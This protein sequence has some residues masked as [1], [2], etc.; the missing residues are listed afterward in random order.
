MPLFYDNFDN[1][2][3]QLDQTTFIGGWVVSD[4]TVDLIGA[5]DFYDALPGNGRYLDLDG[6]SNQA[7]TLSRSLA[8]VGGKTYTASF[9]LAGNPGAAETNVV[10]VGFGTVSTSFSLS[11]A[12]VP[13]VYAV[14][15]TPAT[16]G[17]YVL[18]FHNQGGD[19]YGALLD[20]VSV[21]KADSFSGDG[22][23]FTEF[24]SSLDYG[25][26]VT[27]QPD[28]KILLAGDSFYTSNS[29]A[30]VRYNAN[31]MLDN[32]FSFDGRAGTV[33]SGDVYDVRSVLDEV[34]SV[35][36]QADGNILLAGM[37]SLGGN[38]ALVRYR[39]NGELDSSF[40]GDGMLTTSFADGGSRVR[41]VTVQDDGK[42]LATGGYNGDFAL[43]RYLA[44]GSLDPDFSGTLASADFGAGDTGYSIAVQADGKI[45]VAG[46]TS[47]ADGSVQ[48]FALAR[49]N[50]NGGLDTTFSG[51]GTVTTDIGGGADYA[52]AVATQADG[53]I[54]VAGYSANGLNNDFALA[55]YNKNGSLD[56]SFSQ[57]GKVTA[58]FGVGDDVAY[59]ILVQADGKI[60]LAGTSNDM[61]DDADFALV[62]YN[63]N[64]SL[65][66]LFSGD[67]MVSNDIHGHLDRAQSA[68]LQPDGKILLAGTSYDGVR[69]QF[70][71]VRYNPDGS[72]DTANRQVGVVRNGTAGDDTLNGS[73]Y[74]DK[75]TGVAG[76]DTLSGGAGA[77]TLNGGNG[78]DLLVGGLGKDNLT[79]GTGAD[80]FDFNA[81]ADSGIIVTTRD[82]I[83]DF[84]RSEGDQIDLAGIDADALV[85][86][87]Q[88]FT[89]I[90]TAAFSAGGQLRYDATTHILSGSTDAD[91]QAEIQIT[92]TGVAGLVVGDMAL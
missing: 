29:V 81:A 83:S 21:T 85:A 28:G 44:D 4:G 63:A 10:E 58:D 14:N 15:F 74:N 17:D 79:G 66:S 80:R 91:T 19:N 18:S 23:V 35:T 86:G 20:N 84:H 34:L 70:V 12:T 52:L 5:P 54:L 13:A 53:K 43:S 88:A 26:R 89:F 46:N 36:A 65:D 76:N 41:A 11:A 77:D 9:L 38:L 45:L 42:I 69:N 7:G 22:V 64:G 47:A 78:A 59:S 73:A 68:T 2:G 39:A 87:N 1:D 48:R 72:F 55:R 37:A 16:S 51:D 67:G 71:V 92:L 90:G 25:R 40:D 31:G 61:T 82:V 62:R 24:F 57:D 49:F 60:L 6:S 30:V 32:G 50:P 27:V 75:L 8:L 3:L 56:T 33:V